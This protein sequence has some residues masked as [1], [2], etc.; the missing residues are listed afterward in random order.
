MIRGQWTRGEQ[1]INALST[2]LGD[3]SKEKTMD[4]VYMT[5]MF[6]GVAF[7]IVFVLGGSRF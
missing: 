4:I 5:I 3:I 6:G 2:L 7:A 1:A